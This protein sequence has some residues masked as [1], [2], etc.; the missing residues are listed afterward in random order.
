MLAQL[1]QYADQL[2]HCARSHRDGFGSEYNRSHAAD[3]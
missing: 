3:G 2:N 1:Q